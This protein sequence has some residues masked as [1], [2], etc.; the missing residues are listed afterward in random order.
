[1]PLPPHP[2]SSQPQIS[3][4]TQPGGED[5]VSKNIATFAVSSTLLQ[6]L[7][8]AEQHRPA[9]D[10]AQMD[11]AAIML[12]REGDLGTVEKGKLADIVAV[13]GNP[14]SDV[15]ELERVTFVMKGGQIFKG[16]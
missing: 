3:G 8:S 12:E 13:Q 10:F 9:G 16:P 11:D 15:H 5:G 4:E 7:H 14:L 6:N 1:M 2:D